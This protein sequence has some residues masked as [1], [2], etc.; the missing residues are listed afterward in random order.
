MAGTDSGSSAEPDPPR[1]Q[2][3]FSFRGISKDLLI[4]L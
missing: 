1:P 4:D 3:R 2:R